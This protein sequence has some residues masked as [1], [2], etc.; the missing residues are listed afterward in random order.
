[1]RAAAG[2]GVILSAGAAKTMPEPE[3]EPEA[4][5]KLLGLGGLDPF[6]PGGAVMVV[7]GPAFP[8]GRRG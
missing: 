2:K 7:A 6:H 8:T 3:P 4:G 5:G 1:M